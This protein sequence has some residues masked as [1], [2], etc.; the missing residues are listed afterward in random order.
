MN[1]T[2]L[3]T[4]LLLFGLISIVGC[5]NNK[6]SEVDGNMH[7]EEVIQQAVGEAVN[8]DVSLAVQ[9]AIASEDYRLLHSK[10]RRVVVPGLEQLTLPLLESQCGLKPMKNSTD[11]IKSTEQ[12]QQQK[13]QY[14]FAK[15]FNQV[16]YTECLK[17]IEK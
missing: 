11:V 16:I 15:A 6:T 5:D 8:S 2:D 10:G 9:Q 12:R 3:P 14:A 4:T 13:A 7:E 1:K 17:S